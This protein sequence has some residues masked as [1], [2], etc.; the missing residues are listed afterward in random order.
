MK[1]IDY[2]GFPHNVIVED[3]NGFKD[4]I[5]FRLT[6]NNNGEQLWFGAVPEGGCYAFINE[7]AETKFYPFTLST[8]I[9][10]N[11]NQFKSKYGK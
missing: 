5:R 2:T 1:V 6:D 10:T 9:V 11:I 8:D 3:P 4:I 7:N